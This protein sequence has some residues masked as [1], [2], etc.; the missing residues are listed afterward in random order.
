LFLGYAR[1]GKLDPP[2]LTADG[3]LPT[4]DLLIAGEDGT[5]TIMGR[6]K[7]VIIR[8]GRNLDITEIERAIASHPRVAQVCVAPVPDEVLGERAAA[9]IVAADGGAVRLDE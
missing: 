3:F 1:G 9:L 6:E 7:D 4:G 5:V 8:G 2:D